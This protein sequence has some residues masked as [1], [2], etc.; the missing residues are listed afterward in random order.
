MKKIILLL[1]AILFIK[2]AANAQITITQSDMPVL[3]MTFTEVIDT[4]CIN[5]SFGN[6]GTNQTWN[7]TNIGSSF[8]SLSS[9]VSPASRPGAASFPTAT[10]AVVKDGSLDSYLKVSATALEML[11]I[12]GDFGAPIGVQSAIFTPAMKYFQLPST[13]QTA[14]TGSYTF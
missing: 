5:V 2:F 9:C 12:N 4:N 3:N 8:Q 6:A 11:G 7:L 13:Y 10:M 14:F 1:F